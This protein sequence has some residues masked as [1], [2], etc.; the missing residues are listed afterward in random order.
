MCIAHLLKVA[1]KTLW[2]WSLKLWLCVCESTCELCSLLIDCN[3]FCTDAAGQECHQNVCDCWWCLQTKLLTKDFHQAACTHMKQRGQLYYICMQHL[4]T[5][6]KLFNCQIYRW[7][8]V[9]NCVCVVQRSTWH[10]T[11]AGHQ[12]LYYRKTHDCT[13]FSVKHAALAVLLLASNPAF[14]QSL[15]NVQQYV[16]KLLNCRYLGHDSICRLSPVTSNNFL[17]FFSLILS[18]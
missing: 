10:A 1:K 7:P 4:F 6:H 15:A 17:P 12:R 9:Y 18:W 2:L 8:A 5:L 3:N 11:H 16:Q 14:R 13:F